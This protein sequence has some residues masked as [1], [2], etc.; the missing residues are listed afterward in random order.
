MTASW[1]RP[2]G[3][4]GLSLSFT[5]G[6]Q[7]VPVISFY[8]LVRLILSSFFHVK[9]Q[10]Q[11]GCWLTCRQ[12]Q[13]QRKWVWHLIPALLFSFLLMQ[14]WGGNSDD[15][16]NWL[17]VTSIGGLDWVPGF[18]Q[19]SPVL[20]IKDPHRINWQDT[21]SLCLLVCHFVS[22]KLKN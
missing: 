4:L 12:P 7:Q 21:L 15:S 8:V 11:S 1:W 5:T 13:D 14:T 2:S 10:M 6:Q 20:A 18:G 17:P 19:P 22:S 9:N 3:L 16:R